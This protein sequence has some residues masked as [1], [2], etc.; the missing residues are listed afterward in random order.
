M[1][2]ADLMRAV[3]EIPAAAP[4]YEE[5]ERFYNGDIDEVFASAIIAHR[6]GSSA[7]NYRFNLARRV[8]DAKLDRMKLH[9]VTVPGDDT[10]TLRLQELWDRNKLGKSARTVHRRT[11]SEGD[12]Y[13]FVWEDPDDETGAVVHQRPAA[14]CRVYYDPQQPGRK[15][16]ASFMWTEG[17]GVDK[18]TRITLLYAD[19]LEEWITRAGMSGEKPGDWE[20]YL[21]EDAGPDDWEIENPY[22]EVPVFHFRTDET[23]GRPDHADAYGP[24]NAINKFVGIYLDSVDFQ[25]YPQRWRLKNP[26]AAAATPGAVADNFGTDLDDDPGVVDPLDDEPETLTGGPGTLLDLVDTKAVGQFDATDGQQFINGLNF[27]ARAMGASTGT[28][29]R[30]LEPSGDVPSGESLRADD[31]PLAEAIVDRQTWIGDEWQSL[32]KFLLKVAG[33]D[34]PAVKVSWRPVQIVSDL[35]GWQT[36]RAKIDA[37]VPQEIALA[38]AGYRPEEVEEWLKGSEATNLATRVELVGK[39]AQAMQGLGTAVALGV[40]SQEQVQRVV[41]E[42]LG[43]S[44]E[45][46]EDVA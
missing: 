16:H 14:R 38:E 27:F 44:T 28:P 23:Y 13:A 20:H 6:I 4:K 2:T 9:S 33:I 29:L 39:I 10:A 18:R 42:L 40:V 3:K 41:A 35:Q 21:P 1:S 30:F 37:G 45:Q 31:A 5:G 15:T 17:E 19:R 7:N 12:T 36:V 46:E 34:V 11:L 25:G 8:I 22:G 24:Q 43:D 32:L 26:T